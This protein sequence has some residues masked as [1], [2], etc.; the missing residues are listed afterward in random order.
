[1]HR[2]F[3][4]HHTDG[5]SV[6]KNVAYYAL[7]H[8][9]QFVP[10]GSVRVSSTEMEQLASVAFLSPQHKMVLVVSNTANF[11]K[12]FAVKYHDKF[13]QTTLPSESVGTYVW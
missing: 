5:D 11:A 8:F 9:S 7:E 1:M 13:F 6:T 2:L 3:R 4:G 10:P 12:P